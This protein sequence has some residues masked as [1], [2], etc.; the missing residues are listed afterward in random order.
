MKKKKL[1][2]PK[3][4]SIKEILV[5]VYIVYFFCGLVAWCQLTFECEIIGY[6]NPIFFFTP[7]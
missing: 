2:I 7:V 5:G 1:S 4:M 6:R 3:K